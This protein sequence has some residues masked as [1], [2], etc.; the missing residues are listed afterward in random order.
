M[1]DSANSERIRKK[2]ASILP[3]SDAA[4]T[5]LLQYGNVKRWSK[6]ALLLK[7]GERCREI[8]FIEDGAIKAFQVKEGKDINLSFY[9]EGEFATNLKSLRQELPSEH[10]LQATEELLTCTFTKADLLHL[11]TLSPE[12]V[13]WGR[14]LLESLVIKQEEHAALF[15]LYSPAERYTWLL[16]HEPMFIQRLSVSQI[17]SYLGITRESLS[18]IRK[19]IK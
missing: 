18:R 10:N 14:N 13:V 5:L 12:I 9:F 11:Y 6:G 1:T 15:K 3:L 19:R 17:A 4:C 8:H 2:M 7:E 16:T